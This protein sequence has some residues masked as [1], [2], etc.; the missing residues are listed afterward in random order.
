MDQSTYALTAGLLGIS[1]ERVGDH[2]KALESY[3]RGLQVDP[4]NDGMLYYRG[5]LLY[6]SSP[7]AITDFERAVTSGTAV[8]L[9]YYFLAHH[10]L[11]NGHSK[12]PLT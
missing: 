4:D 9:P 6:G 2:R 1:Y 5:I 3:S 7:Q 8:F 12:I 11:I 10:Y